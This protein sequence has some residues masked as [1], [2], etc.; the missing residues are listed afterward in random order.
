MSRGILLVNLGTPDSA[1]LKDVRRYLGEFLMDRHVID[2]PAPLRG[3]LVYGL[4]LPFR[5]RRSAAAYRAIWDAAGPGSGSPLLH[6][7]RNLAQALSERL[8]VPCELAMRYGSPD[9]ERAVARLICA[10]VKQIMLIALYPQHA[11]STRT[12]TIEAVANALPDDV[13][14]QILPAFYADPGYIKA[15]ADIIERHLP[16]RWDHLLLS[17]H[18]LP[19]QHLKSA[20]PTGSHCLQV[21]NCC[22]VDSVAHASCYRHQV[23]RTSELLTDALEIHSERYTVSFQSRLGRLPWLT[24]YTDQT[25]IELAQQGVAD[26]VVACPAFIADNLE[27]L[28]EIGIAGRETFI[29]NG[30]SSFTLIPCLNDDRQWVNVL[31][32]WFQ[33]EPASFDTA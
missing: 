31:A 3:L 26:L 4:I 13:E 25:L 11:D 6:Y 24:P 15:Q 21:D 10:G 7:S 22:Q 29:S 32:G 16:A 12:T 27:T 19:E 17:F 20:D 5:P 33:T 2:L 14:L 9:I 23:Y 30:G 28:E 8:Q 18:G 1:G